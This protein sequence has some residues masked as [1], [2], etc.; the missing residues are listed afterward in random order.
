[1]THRRTN[2]FLQRNIMFFCV[3]VSEGVIIKFCVNHPCACHGFLLYLGNKDF[4]L[5]FLYL[6]NFKFDPAI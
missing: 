6:S 4:S 5:S 2:N 1:M 3:T